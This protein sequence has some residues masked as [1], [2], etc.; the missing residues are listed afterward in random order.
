MHDFWTFLGTLVIGAP[1]I[2]FA[3]KAWRSSEK[4][5]GAVNGRMDEFKLLM[6]ANGDLL[7]QIEALKKFQ[8]PPQERKDDEKPNGS[9]PI[10]GT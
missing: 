6:Q 3:F 4:T 1:A 2:I 10:T 8:Q 9:R 7:R 5:H